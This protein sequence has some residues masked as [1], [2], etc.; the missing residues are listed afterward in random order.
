M[1]VRL[2]QPIYAPVPTVF[3]VEGITTELK[4]TQFWKQ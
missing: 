1:L 4:D 3:T 2:L